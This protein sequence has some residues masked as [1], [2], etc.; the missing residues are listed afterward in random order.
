MDSQPITGE[1]DPRVAAMVFDMI[2]ER[3]R[4]QAEVDAAYRAGWDARGDHEFGAGYV[5]CAEDVKADQH[6]AVRDLRAHLAMWGGLR[7]RFADPR[8]GDVHHGTGT[9]TDDERTAY[10]ARL[11]EETEAAAAARWAEICE[12]DAQLDDHG[13]KKIA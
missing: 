12:R 5:Q 11:R 9:M 6:G 10:F 2:E 8:P 7:T 3:E 13:R 4:H 1:L